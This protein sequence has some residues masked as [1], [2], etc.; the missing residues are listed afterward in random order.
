LG[1]ALGLEKARIVSKA[2]LADEKNA[3]ER[4]LDAERVLGGEFTLIAAQVRHME[5]TLEGD[6]LNREEGDIMLQ[7]TEG[8]DLLAPEWGP[9]MEG[10]ISEEQK[11][12]LEN[13]YMNCASTRKENETG[14]DK[15][16]RRM[17][18][19][20]AAM[21]CLEIGK[22]NKVANA[23][24]TL[25]KLQGKD[26][27][28]QEV[29]EEDQEA[30]SQMMRKRGAEMAGKGAKASAGGLGGILGSW[31]QMLFLGAA[32]LAYRQAKILDSGHYG[33]QEEWISFLKGDAANLEID[34]V[35]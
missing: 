16:L 25:R 20:L 6:W 10:K 13:T 19:T 29:S 24:G 30:L 33:N 2:L 35:A 8:E 12:I 14:R 3:G 34:R 5:R 26:M 28:G 4:E 1:A 23:L 17:S 31:P 7:M 22:R 11:K 18:F 9:H 21:E 15:D 32:S 27:E